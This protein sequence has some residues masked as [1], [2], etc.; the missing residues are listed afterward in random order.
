MILPRGKIDSLKKGIQFSVLLDE[1]ADSKKSGQCIISINNSTATLVFDNGKCLLAS[2]PPLAG[3]EAYNELIKNEKSVVSAE[4]YTYSGMQTKLCIEYNPSFLVSED[5]LNS[6]PTSED[7]SSKEKS[8]HKPEHENQCRKGSE[9][10]S[11]RLPH[12][13][14][15]SHEKELPFFQ[16]IR[17][18]EDNNFY[19]FTSI[20]FG[21]KIAKLVFRDGLCLLADFPPLLGSAATEKLKES[22]NEIIDAELYSLTSQQI[23]LAIEFNGN[24]RAGKQI[25]KSGVRIKFQDLNKDCSNNKIL[26]EKRDILPVAKIAENAPEYETDPGGAIDDDFKEQILT[27]EHMK[28]DGV[29]ERFRENFKEVIKRLDLEYLLNDD[30][31]QKLKNG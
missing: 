9:V 15:L 18:I 28:K 10:V 14:F 19:G 6:I 2:M 12:G 22:G 24:F 4:I 23:D 31:E 3:K 21:D 25:K 26:H 13:I 17:I 8:Y 16:L 29:T 30:R 27:L 11:I 1:L 5:N 7:E 20:M